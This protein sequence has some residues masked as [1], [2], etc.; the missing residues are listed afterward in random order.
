VNDFF[1][2]PLC[3]LDSVS[4]TEHNGVKNH[5]SQRKKQHHYETTKSLFRRTGHQ[6]TKKEN[7]LQYEENLRSTITALYLV[8]PML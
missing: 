5:H 1:L 4:I 7:P 3:S 6:P 8:A 2:T